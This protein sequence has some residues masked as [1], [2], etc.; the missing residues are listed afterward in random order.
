[1][2]VK[3]E[4]IEKHKRVSCITKLYDVSDLHNI[5]EIKGLDAAVE[6]TKASK[7]KATCSGRCRKVAFRVDKQEAPSR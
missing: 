3:K 1:M 7:Q 5:E 4:R 6:V 2:E